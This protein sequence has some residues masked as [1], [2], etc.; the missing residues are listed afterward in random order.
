MNFL[1]KGC[2]ARSMQLPAGWSKGFLPNPSTHPKCCWTDATGRLIRSKVPHPLRSPLTT[3]PQKCPVGLAFHHCGELSEISIVFFFFFF[4]SSLCL[5]PFNHTP[6]SPKKRICNFSHN[7]PL[8]PVPVTD[9]IFLAPSRHSREASTTI[10]SPLSDFWESSG[11]V[12][13]KIRNTISK[14]SETSLVL[15]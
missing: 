6:P 15:K 3:G 7:F 5:S 14:M 8:Y 12:A 1:L 2:L 11:S 10:R 13:V 9:R 4:Y